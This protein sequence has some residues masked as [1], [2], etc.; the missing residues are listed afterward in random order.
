[1][2]IGQRNKGKCKKK[3]MQIS[4]PRRKIETQDSRKRENGQISQNK[5]DLFSKGKFEVAPT[6]T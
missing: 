4:Q 5:I 2:R 1:M 3:D 6:K